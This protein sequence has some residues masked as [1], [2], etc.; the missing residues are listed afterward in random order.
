M[1]DSTPVHFF[2]ILSSL[3][4]PAKA[5]SPNTMKTR[6]ILNYKGVPYTQTYVSYP[7]IAPLLA[8]LSVKP[9][10]EGTSIFTH[11]L[12]AICH[13]SVTS[14]PSGALMDSLPIA[15]HLDDLYPSPP[16]FPSGNASY[17]L[18]LA[19]NKLMLVITSS[20]YH[21]VAP[22][23]AHILDARGKEYFVRTRTEHFGKPLSEVRPTGVQEIQKMKENIAVDARPLL[24]MLQGK[25]GKSGPFFEGDRPGYADFICVSFLVWFNTADKEIFQQLVGLGNGELKTLWDA[26]LPWVEGQGEDKEWDIPQ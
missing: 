10:P 11:T 15:I 16:L 21:F 17:A 6:M 13:P 4:V 1:A 2:D 14:N 18:A 19:V 23:V 9:Y 26:C 25:P 12:P 5:W 8:S 24:E 22:E 20:V 3:P 7:D